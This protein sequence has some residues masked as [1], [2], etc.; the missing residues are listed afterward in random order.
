MI[1]FIQ[2]IILKQEM[3]IEVYVIKFQKVVTIPFCLGGEP[4][5]RY[6]VIIVVIELY[7][8]FLFA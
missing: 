7:Y 1:K 6:Y 4:Q 2:E 8:I 5:I 3:Y